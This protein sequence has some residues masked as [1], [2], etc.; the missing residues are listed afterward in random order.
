[1]SCLP[2]RTVVTAASLGLTGPLL[3]STAAEA[4]GRALVRT[5]QVPVGGGVVIAG[6]KVVVTQP[7]RGRFRV[8]SAVCTH[9][10]C[11]VNDV[12]GGRIHCPCHGS[13]FAIGDGRAVAGPASSSLPLR[14]HRVRDGKIYLA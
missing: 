12:E 10:G 11:L 5:S 7:R 14:K 13:E 3:V 8:F 4:A 9:Q 1:M 2:R 6:R